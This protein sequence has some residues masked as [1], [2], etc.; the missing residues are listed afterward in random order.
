ME[1][2]SL[3]LAAIRWKIVLMS[4]LLSGCFSADADMI[5]DR[6]ST[7][8]RAD[9]VF[10]FAEGAYW[11]DATGAESPICS[12]HTKDDLAE[13]CQ[14][15]EYI[16]LERTERGNYI[17]QIFLEDFVP[18]IWFRSE[19]RDNEQPLYACLL[20]IDDEGQNN[21]LIE[22]P[23]AA[24]RLKTLVE[25]ARR[26]VGLEHIDREAMLKLVALYERTLQP[27]KDGPVQCPVQRTAIDERLL[28]IV[29]PQ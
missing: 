15:G 21:I 12:V 22:P 27:K 8:V 6:A 10:A 5:G 13:P 1:K 26:L 14:G 2:R 29:D 24:H 11:I 28:Q 18:M 3:A 23:A 7:L 19:R 17:V 9:Q 4:L 20:A 16:K 25:K